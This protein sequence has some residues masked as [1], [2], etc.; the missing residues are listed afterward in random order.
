MQMEEEEAVAL[1][2]SLCPKLFSSASFLD[3]HIARRHAAPA[4]AAAASFVACAAADLGAGAG[5]GG[6]AAML[7]AP[8][9]EAFALGAVAA[10]FKQFRK[11]WRA[12][13]EAHLAATLSALE[14]LFR[15]GGAAFAQGG[16]GGGGGGGRIGSG[17]KRRAS[18]LDHLSACSSSDGKDA[19]AL[20]REQ[21]VHSVRNSRVPWEIG[22]SRFVGVRNVSGDKGKRERA[23]WHVRVSP[24]QLDRVVRTLE[25]AE[26]LIVEALAA[27]GQPEAALHRSTWSVEAAAR[28]ATDAAVAEKAASAAA[29]KAAA[30]AAAA[31]AAAEEEVEAKA[32]RQQL[33]A[34]AQLRETLARSRAAFPSRWHPGM[35]R[36]MGVHVC[37]GQ[38]RVCVAA[39]GP[40][41]TLLRSR[42]E[43]EAHLVALALKRGVQPHELHRPGWSEGAELRAAAAAAAAAPAVEADQ[44]SSVV[45]GAAH[46]SGKAITGIEEEVEEV[47]E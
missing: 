23:G 15:R 31:A 14:R 30:K 6:G 24:L 42:A 11:E 5:A 13:S 34:A 45:A 18:A 41:F 7:E 22:M 27:H 19:S 32:A 37:G 47:G 20:L 46:A 36:Y 25:E 38:W 29:V 39:F 1:P 10:G 21:L 28:A 44:N 43:A 8:P 17:L 40:Q 2:C 33:S 9:A 26:A 3:A 16:A 12:A 4:A 35:S